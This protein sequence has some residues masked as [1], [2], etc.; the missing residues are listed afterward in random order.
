MHW[1]VPV[2]GLVA[3]AAIVAV[4]IMLSADR[5]AT[6]QVRL[7]PVGADL[8]AQSIAVL[9]FTNNTGVDSLDWLGPGLANMLTTG[10]VQLDAQTVVGAQ[11]LLDLLRQ[12]GHEETERIPEDLA[13]N[14]AAGSGAHLLAYSSFVKLGDDFRLDVQ[15]ID[16]GNGTVVGAEHARGANLFILVDSVSAR[17]STRVLGR[18]VMP[19]ELTPVTQ[20]TT[21]SLSAYREYQVGRVA[22]GRFLY[23]TA[24]EHFERAV[25]LDSTFA[26]AW[27]RL[28]WRAVVAGDLQG[29][30]TYLQRAEKYSAAASQKDHLWIQAGLAQAARRT[31]EA[32]GYLE[33]LVAKYPDDKEAQAAL[34]IRYRWLG[35]DAD[36]IRMQEQVL[37]LDPYNIPALN[38]LAN[39]VALA[40]D[41]ARADS[42]SLRYIELEP[43]Q[44][45]PYDTRGEILETFGRYEEA[46]AMFREAVSL[47]PTWWYSMAR[48][49]R[50]YLKE[51]NPAGG[52]EALVPFRTAEHQDLA[53]WA[54]LL[55][56]DTYDA[57]GRYLDALETAR[58]AAEKASDLG[59]D[60]LRLTALADAGQWAIA[61]GRYD[62]AE[63]IF[64]ERYLLYPQRTNVLLR[65]LTTFGMQE[66]FDEMSR[67][68]EGAGANIDAAPDF[69]R[70]TAEGRVH[71]ADGLIAWYRD[72]NPE[73]TVR[74]FGEGRAAYGITTMTNIFVVE[75]ILALIEVGQAKEALAILDSRDERQRLW[76]VRHI[77]AHTTWY[78]RGRAHEALGEP[79]QA[80]ESYQ[81]LLDAAGDGVRE[82]VL[83]R[84]TPERVERLRGES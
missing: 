52:R 47:D 79:E 32:V 81:R 7:L 50:T 19:T 84:D 31:G 72:G 63:A 44:P 80:L 46:R 10:L 66:H 68:R 28:G 9:P 60:D 54:R 3:I 25:E 55:E 73:E 6:R 14:I 61:T 15:L 30:T 5:P 78:L 48:L 41:E 37:R 56:A 27:L 64:R 39:Q 42:L 62:E 58:A 35:R 74:L 70:G 11:R 2:I 38:E 13:L 34:G 40:G 83:F 43:N 29:A 67:V 22:E 59:R 23:P 17:L 26:L 69:M 4:W 1:L 49:V 82:V 45:N 71:F 20:L 36:D 21:G 8:G 12:A 57:E 77:L 16:S 76:Q 51:G 33:E 53:W 18:T 75:E 24:L 65:I